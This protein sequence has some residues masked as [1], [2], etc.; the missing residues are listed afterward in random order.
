MLNSLRLNITHEPHYGVNPSVIFTISFN[1]V[2]D[3]IHLDTF[4][5]LVKSYK[6]LF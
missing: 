6:H 5:T 2:K 3:S 1:I 4:F